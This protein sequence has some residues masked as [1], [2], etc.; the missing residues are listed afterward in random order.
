MRWNLKNGVAL[1]TLVVTVAGCGMVDGRKDGPG[2]SKAPRGEPGLETADTQPMPP[3]AAPEPYN[4]AD[5]IQYDD[6]GYAVAYGDDMQGGQTASGEPFLADAIS[7]AHATLPM[8]SYVEITRLDSGKTIVA[9]VNDRAPTGKGPILGLSRGTAMLLG[10]DGSGNAPVRVRKVNPTEQ[11]KAA[12]RSGLKGGDRLDT[13]APLL[14][15]LRKK[16]G[17]SAPVAVAAAP[18]APVTKPV[19]A[20]PDARAASMPARPRPGQ[21]GPTGRPGADYSNPP[22]TVSAPRQDPTQSTPPADDPFIVEDGT[23]RPAR[24]VAAAQPSMG[25][26]R[27]F[28]QVAAFSAQ[29][30][31]VSLA[32]NVGGQVERAGSVYRVKM[33]PY[34]DEGSARAAL[35]QAAAKGYRD[36]RITR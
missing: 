18:R 32:R 1:G 2:F 36:A 30:R 19:A 4:P 7:V 14:V 26:G 31:A 15:A 10:L 17:I 3:M 35:G 27:Y 6:V 22:R 20:A 12:L 9:R 11:E 29:T 16:M 28:V 25:T 13:P 5:N 33:G 21:V 34:G 24:A 8:P 23:G